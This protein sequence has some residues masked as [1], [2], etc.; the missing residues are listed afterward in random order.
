MKTA[1]GATMLT[2]LRYTTDHNT[3]AHC[4]YGYVPSES[5]DFRMATILACNSPSECRK[6]GAPVL[7]RW[8]VLVAI[9]RDHIVG[10]VCRRQ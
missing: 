7:H 1:G 2:E 8:S 10:Q 9:E 3:R 5:H 4:P 6:Q